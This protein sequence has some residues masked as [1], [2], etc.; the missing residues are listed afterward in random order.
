MQ[1]GFMNVD[2]SAVVLFRLVWMFFR[3]QKVFILWLAGRLDE[4]MRF[5]PRATCGNCNTG[6]AS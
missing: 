3:E 6:E 1:S 2:N 5:E 4:T